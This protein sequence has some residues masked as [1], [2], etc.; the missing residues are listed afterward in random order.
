MAFH[1]NYRLIAK[2]LI[3]FFVAELKTGSIS[4]F[5]GEFSSGPEE[6]VVL[7]FG[8]YYCCSQVDRSLYVAIS[9]FG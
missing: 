6:C 9:L 8:R 7:I 1:K 5:F 2:A 3:L 4:G